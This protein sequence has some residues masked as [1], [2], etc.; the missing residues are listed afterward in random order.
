MRV[1]PAEVTQ[2]AAYDEME[3]ENRYDPLSKKRK[4]ADCMRVV[5]ELREDKEKGGV[6]V[7]SK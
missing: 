4:V 2:C 1:R 7:R 3:N 5:V 6:N